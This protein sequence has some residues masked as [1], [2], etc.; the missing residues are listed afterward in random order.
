MVDR[1]SCPYTAA[2]RLDGF[3]GKDPSRHRSDGRTAAEALLTAEHTQ[4]SERPHRGGGRRFD[5]SQA[6]RGRANSLA[7]PS[8][9]RPSGTDLRNECRKPDTCG[10]GF[11]E[12]IE[13]ALNRQAKEMTF[14][15]ISPHR[16]W[17]PFPVRRTSACGQALQEGEQRPGDDLE[18]AAGGRETIPSSQS[19]RAYERCLSGSQVCEWSPHRRQQPAIR[20]ACPVRDLRLATCDLRPVTSFSL[21]CDRLLKFQ[22]VPPPAALAPF[23]KE[24]LSSLDFHGSTNDPFR[25]WPPTRILDRTRLVTTVFIYSLVNRS[26]D[27][28]ILSILYRI[29]GQQIIR[30]L[31]PE[32][33]LHLRK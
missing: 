22:L 11:G 9:P 23:E 31:M 29:A 25:G 19:S 10:A 1:P 12:K 6:R 21:T 8:V 7:L 15:V 3:D 28:L 27:W 5:R 33:L 13:R 4:T 32:L 18:D 2:R 14:R 24:T 17:I 20:P 16:G 26:T 30:A